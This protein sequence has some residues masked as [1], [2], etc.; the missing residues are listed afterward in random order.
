MQVNNADVTHDVVLSVFIAPIAIP[1]C[2]ARH[3][4]FDGLEKGAHI[5]ISLHANCADID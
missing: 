2:A 5:A 4:C 1:L 3:Y